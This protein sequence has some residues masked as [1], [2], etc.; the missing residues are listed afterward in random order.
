MIAEFERHFDPKERTRILATI[1][2]MNFAN[3][4]V[5]T[6]GSLRGRRARIFG[7]SKREN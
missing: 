2:G 4:F 7:P 5:N 6:F 1:M 3:R